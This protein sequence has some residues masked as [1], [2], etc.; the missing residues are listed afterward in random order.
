MRGEGTR[1]GVTRRRR[2]EDEVAE[3]CRLARHFSAGRFARRPS[4][5]GLRY[6]DRRDILRASHITHHTPTVV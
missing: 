1:G 2:C 5:T 3:S 6:E 4:D